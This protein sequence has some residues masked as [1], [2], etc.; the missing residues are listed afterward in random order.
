MLLQREIE[1]GRTLMRI[2]H[3]FDLYAR[4]IPHDPNLTGAQYTETPGGLTSPKPPRIRQ[5]RLLD[6]ARGV[7]GLG[8]RQSDWKPLAETEVRR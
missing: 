5:N 8:N 4:V 6:N 7:A 2:A 3:N 1:E